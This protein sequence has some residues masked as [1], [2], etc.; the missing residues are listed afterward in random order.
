MGYLKDKSFEK[1]L[2]D[3]FHWKS[4]LNFPDKKELKKMTN[5]HHLFTFGTYFTHLKPLVYLLIYLPTGRLHYHI[6]NVSWKIIAHR[7]D[8]YVKPSRIIK[9][10]TF[11]KF[12]AC[13]FHPSYISYT[14][15]REIT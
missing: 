10:R 3:N 4:I 2:P 13:F 7:D 12:I 15:N 1:K 5:L 9:F 8:K 14:L 11:F 6:D